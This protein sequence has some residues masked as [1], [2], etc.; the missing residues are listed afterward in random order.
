MQKWENI[1]A[2]KFA[3]FFICGIIIGSQI[4][5]NRIFLLIIITVLLIVAL[6]FRHNQVISSINIF[7]IIVAC[8][9]FKSNID[10]HTLDE[11]SIA[12]LND[13]YFSKEIVLNGKVKDFP[14]IDTARIRFVLDCN[15]II[16][17]DTLNVEGLIL[18]SIKKNKYR[19]LN[20][21]LPDV[22]QGDFIQLRGKLAFPFESRN[23]GEFNYKKYLFLND[24]YNTFFV[25]GF[26]NVIECSRTNE[27]PFYE[28]ALNDFKRYAIE[29]IKNNNPG[30]G[31][32]F[33]MGLVA[34][35][36]SKITQ[37]LKTEFVNAGVMHLIAVSGLNV[38]YVILS[39]M[40][41]LT[42][43]RIP[44]SFKIFI[45]IIFLILY[46]IFTGSSASILRASIMGTLV[47]LYTIIERKR[48]FYNVIGVSLMIILAFN[49]KQLF[50]SGFILS[51]AAVFSMVYI[52]EKIDRNIIQKLSAKEFRGKKIFQVLI[53]LF[54]TTLAAQIGT[55]PLGAVYFEK[56]SVIS[57]VAN[58][59][60]IPLSNIS[61]ALG[62]LQIAV[63]F[64]SDTLSSS[65]AE[66]NNLLLTLQLVFIKFCAGIKFA[67]F[68]L[69][70]FDLITVTGYYLILITIIT[71]KNKKEILFRAVI[72]LLII[73]SIFV[74]RFNFNK[75]LTIT[76]LDV[77]QGDCTLIETP[78]GE[79][80]M[81]D[82][83]PVTGKINYAERNIVPFLGR[84]GIN[85]LDILILTHLHQDHIGGIFYLLDNIQVDKII[86]SGQMTNSDIRRKIDSAIISKKI[87]RVCATGGD[88]IE[89]F[90]DL[91]LYFLF[92][93]K[94]LTA[95]QNR[96]P[97][98]K[99]LNFT[100]IVFKLKF[101]NSEILFS[102][103][104][105]K[106]QE[107]KLINTYD[108]FLKSDLIKIPHHGSNTSSTIPYLLKLN[109]DYSVIFCGL[110]NMYKNPSYLV[111]NRLK[112]MN[113]KVFRTDMDGAAV[114]E[115]DGETIK[116]VKWW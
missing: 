111:L 7:L 4:L 67:Y 54:A 36:R 79:N 100:S 34:G 1:P 29:N 90:N 96:I 65:I 81:I 35:E 26:E 72:C 55:I 63:S 58:M 76:F 45:T 41:I 73:F 84:K 5:I 109:P 20:I 18:V 49:S 2:F 80:I 32:A 75:N 112:N 47:L 99:N 15:K 6:S 94:E 8:G 71:I 10:F 95:I 57:L 87:K 93:D 56:I 70:K 89:I 39:V 59:I 107:E 62:F 46:C 88:I 44:V 11:N 40:L 92:P 12:N 19:N 38:A 85:K 21:N 69:Y 66:T 60:A 3:L 108:N 31:G 115:S 105:E 102:G 30:D 78:N 101:K 91:K 42:L 61:L 24:I 13:K 27:L 104:I 43:F 50:D 33:L 22:N 98:D 114:F 116:P 48:E 16:D 53:I 103:D 14:D 25:N 74:I 110:F 106:T 51:Y 82:C 113:S 77:G 97:D 64:I 83:G 23:P 17:E 86:E 9:I 68:K 37:E 28:K 52:Y